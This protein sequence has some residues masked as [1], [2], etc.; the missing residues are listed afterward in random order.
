MQ[1]LYGVGG[2]RLH[3]EIELGHLEGCRGSA[4]VRIGNDAVNQFQL[5]VYGEV[6]DTI[7][8]YRKHGGEIDDET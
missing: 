7:H 5:D 6:L 3:P 8:L 4:L 2:E 1:I